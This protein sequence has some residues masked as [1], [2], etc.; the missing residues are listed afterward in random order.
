M[1]TQTPLKI[2]SCGR[3]FHS[4]PAKAKYNPAE[5][6]RGWFWECSCNSTLYV[7]IRWLAERYLDQSRKVA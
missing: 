7:P 4:M 1:K 3:E 5:G 2:C 6:L